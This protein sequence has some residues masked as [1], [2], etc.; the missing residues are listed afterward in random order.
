[1]PRLYH[2]NLHMKG[3]LLLTTTNM[4]PIE[5]T[6]PSILNV[7]SSKMR[8]YIPFGALFKQLCMV[9]V[10]LFAKTDTFSS[11]GQINRDQLTDQGKQLKC[12]FVFQY[13]CG[14]TRH[15][16]STLETGKGPIE[17]APSDFINCLL[18]YGRDQLTGQLTSF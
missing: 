10:S 15:K 18:L 8:F 9:T 6:I 3:T 16:K 13:K 12:Y 4:H 1:M 11:C 5:L 17:W 2:A 7:K 14:K